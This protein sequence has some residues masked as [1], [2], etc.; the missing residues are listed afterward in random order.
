MV[1]FL[2]LF[3]SPPEFSVLRAPFSAAPRASLP[4]AA[5]AQADAPLLEDD[6]QVLAAPRA[7]GS[8]QRVDDWLLVS[9]AL[10]VAG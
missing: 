3:S 1:S 8:P 6:S 9:A 5:C 4:E 7:G 2:L 10:P